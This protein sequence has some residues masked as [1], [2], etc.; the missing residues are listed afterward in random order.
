MKPALQF[1]ELLMEDADKMFNKAITK[2]KNKRDGVQNIQ[3]WFGKAKKK[4][5]SGINEDI[6]SVSSSE[7]SIEVI[8][9]DPDPAVAN[10]KFVIKI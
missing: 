7:E 3:K 1:L 6:V 10:S 4:K 8:P 5:V 2:E 9:D